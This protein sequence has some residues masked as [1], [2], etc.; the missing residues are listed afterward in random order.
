[1]N[2]SLINIEYNTYEG[3]RVTPLM[4]QVMKI[5]T[6]LSVGPLVVADSSC[7]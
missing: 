1:M 2:L 6:L 5:A 3:E 7:D 4:V